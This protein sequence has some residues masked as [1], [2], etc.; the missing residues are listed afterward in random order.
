[1]TKADFVDLLALRGDITKKQANDC[2]EIVFATITEVLAEGENILIPGFGKFS[3]V[4]RGPRNGVNPRTQERIR[5]PE[6]RAPR[7]SATKA[8]KESVRG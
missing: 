5:I 8:L 3:V 6:T 1:M 7:F 2:L 4:T